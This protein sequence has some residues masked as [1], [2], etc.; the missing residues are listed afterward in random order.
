MH[1]RSILH[2]IGATRCVYHNSIKPYQAPGE[3][4]PSSDIQRLSM[5]IAA[6]ADTQ[7]IQRQRLTC[8]LQVAHL[9]LQ[10]LKG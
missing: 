4:L 2:T 7:D 8:A 9:L 6:K 1:P 10:E 5:A 3:S